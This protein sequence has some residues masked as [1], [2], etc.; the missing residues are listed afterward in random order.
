MFYVFPFSYKNS[1]GK[2][3]AVDLS[4]QSLKFTQSIIA[5]R[6]LPIYH[7]KGTIFSHVRL[8]LMLHAFPFNSNRSSTPTI[9]MQH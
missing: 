3:F 9:F 2:L 8:E 5:H 6:F 7:Y 1:K 4:N